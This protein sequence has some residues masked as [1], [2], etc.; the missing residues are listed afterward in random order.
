MTILVSTDP[1]LK[2]YLSAI[3]KQLQ[4][5]LLQRKVH[6]IVLVIIKVDTKETLERWEF[7]VDTN[8][9]VGDQEKVEVDINVVQ[10]DIRNIIRQITASVTYLPLLDDK[11]S[12]D[13]LLYTDK[14]TDLPSQEWR[15]STAHL[16]PG[17]EEVELRNFNTKMHN[18]KVGV[19]YKTL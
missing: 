7:T 19:A 4:L 9:A 14:D 6:R 15:D 11:V 2:A 10:T 18:V 3:L 17:A 12:F 16:I 8:Q 5:F 13:I 1:C